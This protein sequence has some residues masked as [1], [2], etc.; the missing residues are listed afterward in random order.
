[1]EVGLEQPVTMQCVARDAEVTHWLR[2]GT[3]IAPDSNLT[4]SGG[5]LEILA[6]KEEQSGE[7]RCLAGDPPQVSHRGLLSYFSKWL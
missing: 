2:D 3:P 5:T 4:I 6:F 7:Y 1:M